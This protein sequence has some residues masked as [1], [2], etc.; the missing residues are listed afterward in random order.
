GAIAPAALAAPVLAG[1]VQVLT[2]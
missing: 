1:V 2:G